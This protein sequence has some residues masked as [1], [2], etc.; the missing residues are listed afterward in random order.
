VKLYYGTPA[1]KLRQVKAHGRRR[2]LRY[3]LALTDKVLA[4]MRFDIR[5]KMGVFLLKQSNTRSLIGL[6]VTGIPVILVW[7]ASRQW[8]LTFLTP[9]MQPELWAALRAAKPDWDYAR[10]EANDVVMAWQT[11]Q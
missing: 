2:A 3:G 4:Q 11:S 10:A 6:Q 1:P 5:N 9:S 8:P 7:D